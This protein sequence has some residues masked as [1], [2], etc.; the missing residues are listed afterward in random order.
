MTYKRLQIHFLLNPH[1]TDTAVSVR[2]KISSSPR[3][4]IA[5]VTF[6]IVIYSSSNSEFQMS[7]N[8]LVE[9]R[10]TPT[11]AQLVLVTQGWAW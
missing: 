8:T 11:L 2:R 9:R 4:L 3:L 5:S 10:K 7:L 6:S 1:Q